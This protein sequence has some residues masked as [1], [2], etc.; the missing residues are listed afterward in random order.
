MAPARLTRPYVGRS[1]VTPQNAAG[2]G[3][4]F[5]RRERIGRRS[6]GIGD[7]GRAA[8]FTVAASEQQRAS[9]RRATG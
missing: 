6:L 2:R 8:A 1:P 7:T 5:L 9:R 3:R 4:V